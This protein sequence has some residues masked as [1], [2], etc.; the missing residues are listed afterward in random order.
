MKE[1]SIVASEIYKWGVNFEHLKRH[2]I[3]YGKHFS[4]AIGLSMRFFKGAIAGLIHAIYPDFFPE[5]M[6]NTCHDI[7]FNLERGAKK[8]C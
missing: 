7:A 2:H 1:L 5:T 8:E 3:T 6:T 4:K